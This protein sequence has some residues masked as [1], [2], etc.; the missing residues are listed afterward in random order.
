M[1]KELIFRNAGPTLRVQP[2]KGNIFRVNIVQDDSFPEK[3]SLV[4][5]NRIADDNVTLIDNPESLELKSQNYTLSVNRNSLSI[6]ISD[7]SGRTV[8]EDGGIALNKKR[9]PR[10]LEAIPNG[11]DASPDGYEYRLNFRFADDEAI[12]GLGSHNLNTLNLRGQTIDLFQHNIKLC[13]PV[14]ISS[15]GY[16]I[17]FD[18]YSMMQFNDA[19]GQ[20]YMQ[21][22]NC[23]LPDFYIICG[24]THDD[25]VKSYRSLIGKVSLLPRWAFGYIQS[26]ERYKSQEELTGIVRRYRQEQV[27]ID[28]IVQDWQYWP[29]GQ[30]G[31]KS[32]NEKFPDPQ[33]M[34]DEIHAM[35]CRVMISIWAKFSKMGENQKE[36]DEQGLLLY[37][38]FYNVYKKKGRDIFY[39]QLR[40]GIL[41][42]GFDVL[43][44]D[45]TEPVEADMWHT[46]RLMLTIPRMMKKNPAKLKKL[47]LK[48]SHR[49]IDMRYANI[50]TLLHNRHLHENWKRDFP[51]KRNMTVTRSSFPGLHRHNAVVWTGD[52]SSTWEVL[53]EQ[54]PS[55]L[56]YSITG[57]PYV[58]CDIGGFF[59]KWYFY[60][61][62][63][64]GGF[65]K[66]IKD[67]GY[68]ELYTRWLQLGT[69]LPVMRSHGTQTPREVW[70]FGQQGEIFYDTI[71]KFIR[72]RY[73]LLPYI[74]STAYAV[75]HDDASMIKPLVMDFPHDDQVRNLTGQFMF[76]ENIMVCPVTRPMYYTRG[77][78]PISV[79]DHS[80]EVYLPEGRWY[81]FWTNELL[82]GGRHIKREAPLETMPLYIKAGSILPMGYDIQHSEEQ[83]PIKLVIYPGQDAEFTLY[84]DDGCSYEHENGAYSKIRLSWNEKEQTLT[85]SDREGSYAREIEFH[86]QLAGSGTHKGIIYEGRAAAVSL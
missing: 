9:F 45:N 10:R 44:T 85:I 22:D 15:R 79:K 73:R 57:E 59:A 86:V 43:W 74:Y 19:G 25:I 81:D 20:S 3:Q 23:L 38:R 58:H 63:E 30:W 72:L 46:P 60:S 49:M 32:F 67:L 28:C 65:P 53:K 77:S 11:F 47:T 1:N 36:F 7:N 83:T 26:K 62:L 18:E 31:Q 17:F 5:E 52:I 51:R 61:H 42:H 75:A 84:D 55:M 29:R 50:F 71:V 27:P 13:V 8:Y 21:V 24:P 82:E 6:K 56:N 48:I 4:V 39:R 35:N 54:I 41:K 33:R 69:F 12:Y 14:M 64:R 78:K 76:G 66:G 37:K 2:I 40:D 80:V 16:G 70:R 34:V 68:R